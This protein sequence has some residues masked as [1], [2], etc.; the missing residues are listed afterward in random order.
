MVI[1][2][3]LVLIGVLIALAF[4]IAL[5]ARFWVLETEPVVLRGIDVPRARDVVAVYVEGVHDT[6]FGFPTGV[7]R[8]DEH[9]SSPTRLIARELNFGGSMGFRIARFGAM[10]PAVLLAEAADAGCMAGLLALM[11][12]MLFAVFFIGP[13][14]AI[15]IIEVILRWLMRSDVTAELQRVA[16]E[17]DACGVRF[18]LR[19]LSAFGVR[20]QLLAGLAKPVLPTAHG[21]SFIEN[22]PEPWTKDRLNVVYA[23]G[24]VVALLLAALIVALTPSL[25]GAGRS[26]AYGSGSVVDQSSS[27]DSSGDTSSAD[28]TDQGTSTD[29]GASTDGSGDTSTDGSEGQGTSTDPSASAASLGDPV[30][31]GAFTI[32]PPDGWV[33]DRDQVD[34]GGYVES[35]WHDPAEPKATFLVDDTV[36]FQGSAEDGAQAVR[37]RFQRLSDYDELDFSATDVGDLSGWRWEFESG[38]LHKV[39]TFVSTCDTGYA[40]LGAAPTDQWDNYADTFA[41][42]TATLSPNC[43]GSGQEGDAG[44]SSSAASPGAADPATVIREHFTRLNDGDYAGAFAL[45]SPHYRAEYPRWPANRATGDPT[46]DVT[47]VGSPDISGDEARVPMTFYARDRHEAKHSDT[48]CRRFDGTVHLRLIHGHWRYDP[49]KNDLK[50]HPVAR[51]DPHCG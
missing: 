15:S 35:R 4:A 37:K 26:S 17:D 34:R 5:I 47:D 19:G 9:R 24:G 31:G 50:H 18:S 39:D 13:I 41:A 29:A 36:G 11:V 45:M 33:Q 10:I 22:A 20:K 44:A 51:D 14:L 32:Q 43:D 28:S 12:G 42:A 16:D 6:R 40:V 21:G 2:W 48:K 7:F 27:Y 38:G 46:I 1:G 3:L 25:H 49:D 23:A 30:D 8:I